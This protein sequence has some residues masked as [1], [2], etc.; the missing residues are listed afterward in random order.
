MS[1]YD[2]R[3][4]DTL[5]DIITRLGVWILFILFSLLC[6]YGVIRGG[7]ALIRRFL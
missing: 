2:R 3:S 7:I 5:L 4:R 1:Y 6:W